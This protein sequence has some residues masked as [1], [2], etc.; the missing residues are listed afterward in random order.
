MAR[1]IGR[2]KTGD[3]LLI[4][5]ARHRV[6]GFVWLA[7]PDGTRWCEWL[8][9]PDGTTPAD[10][11]AAQRHSWLSDGADD[12]PYLWRALDASRVP[13]ATALRQGSSH[14]VEGKRFRVGERDSAS[15]ERI[16]GDVG[17]DMR[18]GARFDYADLETTG[19]TLSVEWDG[20]GVDAYLGRGVSR[21]QVEHWAIAAGTRLPS[22]VV[23][24][25]PRS[26]VSKS[27][28][29]EST[30]TAII[31]VPIFLLAV[32]LESCDRDDDCRQRYNPQ[33]GQ[34]ETVCSDGVRSSG[35]RSFGG[36]GGK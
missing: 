19:Q 4:E 1:L 11:I 30:I 22:V 20:E 14:L 7:A 12:R 15:V 23:S 26:T 25:A 27:S 16:D 6:S 10:A 28:D 9:V 5:G 35:G 13:T 21:G 8:L 18:V 31:M 36:W 32:M 3:A 29:T 17:G 24:A 2:L 33:T 34:Y